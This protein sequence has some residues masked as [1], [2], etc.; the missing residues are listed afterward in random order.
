M[1]HATGRST[2]A[3]QAGVR[4]VALRHSRLNAESCPAASLLRPGSAK[5]PG[6]DRHCEAGR[7]TL[8]PAAGD[9]AVQERSR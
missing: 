2:A 5:P 4:R 6:F 3:E 9:H 7:P 1:K 8:G